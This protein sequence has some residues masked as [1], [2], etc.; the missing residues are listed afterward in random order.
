METLIEGYFDTCLE[1]LSTVLDDSRD[2]IDLAAE[3]V[4][5]AIM[6]GGGLYLFG[7]GHSAL[8]AREAFWR[9]G[10]LAPALPIP[11]PMAGDAERLPGFGRTVLAHYDL[12]PGSVM[13]VISN[14]GINPMPVEIALASKEQDLKVVGVTSL[15]HSR[16]VTSR[17]PSGQKLFQIADIVIDTHGV[18]GD[19]A[20]EVTGL[21]VK[22]GAT[23]TVVG[24]AIIEAITARAAEVM[25][26]KGFE[27]PVIK[28]SNT[29]GG[30]KHNRKL[31]ERYRNFLVRYQVPTV[32]A[33]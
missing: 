8:I 12:Q 18:R 11:D 29:P 4:A 13:I 21:D 10:G 25:A 22:V 14:S 19:A 32:D 15:T 31:S 1:Q 30:D 20:L 6:D 17:A 2:G 23:S 27:P 28:S 9:A 24:A 33:A 7:S 26:E 3:A 16:D 5:E